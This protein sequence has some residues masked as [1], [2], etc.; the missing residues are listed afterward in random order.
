VFENKPKK[1]RTCYHGHFQI[2][3]SVG[4]ELDDAISRELE[5]GTS[6][7]NLTRQALMEHFRL[8]PVTP[9]D[10]DELPF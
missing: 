8:E 2:H 9:A 5:R 10:P 7:A 6:L 3:V 1:R 4:K